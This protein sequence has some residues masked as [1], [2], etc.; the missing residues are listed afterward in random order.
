MASRHT[1]TTDNTLP[2][3]RTN[4]RASRHCH[5]NCTWLYDWTAGCLSWSPEVI[6]QIASLHEK[7]RDARAA[8]KWYGNRLVLLFSACPV[9]T[10]RCPVGSRC[11]NVHVAAR[12]NLLLARVPSDPGVLA[13]LGQVG[14]PRRRHMPPYAVTYRHVPS[15]LG[16]LARLGQGWE[17]VV[18][19]SR[20]SRRPRRHTTT[21]SS[22]SPPSSSSQRAFFLV[23]VTAF[24][25]RAARRDVSHTHAR[26]P[27]R[28]HASASEGTTTIWRRGKQ[29]GRPTRARHAVVAC[30]HMPSHA[31]T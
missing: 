9:C 7:Q 29:A 30:C 4:E 1:P 2:N 19:A 12:Y 25:L 18:V 20:L 24:V 22:S 26:T 8:I 6:W 21:S 10:W 11:K 23:V 14:S 13:R 15:D 27:P 28:T 17:S 5:C 31:V 16:V 3:E